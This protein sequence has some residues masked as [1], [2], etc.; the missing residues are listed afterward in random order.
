M[1]IFETQID[2]TM[3]NI[4]LFIEKNGGILTVTTS[5]LAII[6]TS[7]TL[8]YS[9][10]KFNND[11]ENFS[12]NTNNQLQKLELRIGGL[13]SNLNTITSQMPVKLK[14][15]ITILCYKNNIPE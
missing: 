5:I 7:T 4:L 3:K 12:N 9:L 10:G 6:I 13:E 11:Y 1:F 14:E 8:S 2:K 15:K